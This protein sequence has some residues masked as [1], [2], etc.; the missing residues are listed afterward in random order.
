METRWLDRTLRMRVGV[1]VRGVWVSVPTLTIA[2]R[3]GVILWW[4]VEA[5]ECVEVF[6]ARGAI[7]TVN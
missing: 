3:V 2:S 7:I 5:V 1:F 4:R 6:N